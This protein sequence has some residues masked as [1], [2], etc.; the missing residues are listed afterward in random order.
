MPSYTMTKN[1]RIHPW[2]FSSELL[3]VSTSSEVSSSS[4]SSSAR[5]QSG[6]RSLVT[7]SRSQDSLQGQDLTSK[8]RF[9]YQA[10]KLVFNNPCVLGDHELHDPVQHDQQDDQPD[11]DISIIRI[12]CK[13]FQDGGDQAGDEGG[14]GGEADSLTDYM[15]YI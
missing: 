5:G 9:I 7:T 12:S 8:I 10:I 3:T 13:Q 2:M 6:P 14:S 1:V 11:K 4:L 15:K